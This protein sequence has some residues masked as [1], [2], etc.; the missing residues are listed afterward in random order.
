MDV[1]MNIW[2]TK[3]WYKYLFEKK[4]LNTSWFRVI[5]CRIKGHPH[6]VVWYNPDSLEP[7]MHCRNCRDDLG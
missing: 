4:D 1:T 5:L 2:L 3:E 6:D 7:N